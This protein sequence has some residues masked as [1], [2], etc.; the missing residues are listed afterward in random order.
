MAECAAGET[1]GEFRERERE[2]ESVFRYR[3]PI[4]RLRLIAKEVPLRFASEF[5]LM[6]SARE[7]RASPENP[8]LRFVHGGSL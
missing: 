6:S 3:L 4:R 7:K 5:I 8:R 1:G 2:R